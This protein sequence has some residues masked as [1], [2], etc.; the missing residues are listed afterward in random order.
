MNKPKFVLCW[1]MHQPWYRDS[2]E[3]TY[4]LPW[5]Y[6]HAI[7]DYTDMAAHLESH[8]RMRAV[9][10]FTPVLLEQIDDYASQMG[11]WL[12]D[13][14]AMT[15]PLLN[16]LAGL[17]PVPGDVVARTDLLLAC[18]RANARNM[19][20]IHPPFR[21]LLDHAMIDE[22]KPRRSLLPY[23]GEQYFLDLLT[24]YHL[25]WLGYSLRARDSVKSLLS[26][27]GGFTGE[28]RRHLI[29]VMHEA[30]ANLV[31]R[32]RLLAERGQIELSM[33]PYAHPIVPL[34]IDFGA[35]NCAQPRAPRP[36][37]EDYPGGMQRAQ[38]HLSR[39][40]EV[41]ETHFGIR[42]AGVWLSEGGISDEAV[43]VLDACGIQ[44]TASGEGVWAN[45]IEAA[46]G[47]TQSDRKDLFRCHRLPGS[48]T[49]IY[50]RDDGLSDLI[51][52]EYQ[53]WDA[54]DA[55]RDFVSHV[56][57]IA[58][59]I[60]D[61]PNDHVI[62]VILDGENAWEYYIDN[63]FHFIDALYRALTEC[64]AV[65]LS[66]FAE[67]SRN[68]VASEIDRLCAGS[69]VYG[70]FS[71]WIGEPD[72][73]RA[74]DLLVD[75]KRRYDEVEAD[76]NWDGTQRAQL[77]RQLAICEGSDWFWWFGDHNPARSVQDFDRLYRRQLKDLYLMMGEAPPA[78]LSTPISR[79]G[80]SVEHGGTMKRGG[81]H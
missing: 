80:G 23:L 70:S 67:V 65:E 41:F 42:P 8:P 39:G 78:Q 54:Q 57:N 45:T 4:R 44:W 49:R 27:T 2:H 18:T 12:E 53:Q 1:H 76:A 32:Y 50:F 7:K 79:G 17:E 81:Q 22:E 21:E 71:T 52:F 77:E 5:V 48:G 66:T 69:W 38:W 33:T 51:G 61:D 25:S 9:I 24:W 72:K 19:I 59:F 63:G 58:T 47:D 62:S 16:L 26:R 36:S 6:L 68:C 35:M 37:A 64:D 73:N 13:G 29:E 15:E 30:V 31:S 20:D 60:G 34:M 56:R 40:V 14:R 74:W 43:N 75:A 11:Q 46:S 28:D 55:V 10:N 3:G